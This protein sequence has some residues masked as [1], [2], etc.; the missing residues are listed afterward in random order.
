LM[1]RGRWTMD[2]SWP[3]ACGWW[4]GELAAKIAPPVLFERVADRLPTRGTLIEAK[5][6]GV[7]DIAAN[8]VACENTL[9]DRHD[10][11]EQHHMPE[12]ARPL[13]EGR[14]IG[15]AAPASYSNT[16]RP[17]ER[18]VQIKPAV[19]VEGKDRGRN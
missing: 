11:I 17:A 19:A 10:G 13:C 6:S 15:G 4:Y 9:H 5:A 3:K 18:I 8:A 14:S 7:G 2:D 12:I 16:S 1:D